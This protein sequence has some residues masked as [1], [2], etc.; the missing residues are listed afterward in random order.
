MSPV[1]LL[2]FPINIAIDTI[3]RNY[4]NVKFTRKELQKL[5][6]I[7]TP[8]THFIF[9]NEIYDQID[10]VSMGSPLAPILANLFM[11]YHE[12]DWIEKAQV[13]K[14]TFIKDMLMIFLRF[15]SLN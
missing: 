1:Y 14:P 11:G 4:P 15:L 6:K 2:I 8:E 3:F 10:G 13:A 12:K 9:N 7:A 5:F